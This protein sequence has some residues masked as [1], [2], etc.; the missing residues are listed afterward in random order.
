[1]NIRTCLALGLTALIS[2]GAAHAADVEK[3]DIK[4]SV[5]GKALLYYLPL[6]VTEKLG[7]FKDAGLN[8]EISDFAGG[9]QSLQAQ[10]GGSVD[11]TTGS[12]EH[13]IQ[14]QAQGKPL[15][16]VVDLGRYPGIALGIANSRVASYKSI[17][18]LKGMRIGVTAPGSSTN[19]MVSYLMIKAGLKPEDASFI[20]VGGGAS[21]VAAMRHGQIDA[22]S[23]TDP[24]MSELETAGDIQ[25]IADSRT[26]E[27]TN[28]IYGGPSPAAVLYMRPSF[29]QAN[30]KTT[31]A[32]VDALVRGLHWVQSHSPEQ[33]ADLMPPE[34][35]GGNKTLYT[36]AIKKSLAIYSPDGKFDPAACANT[37]KVLQV[38]DDKVKAASIDLSKTYDETFVDQAQKSVK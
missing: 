21:A 31:Q 38:F 5:G 20:G 26:A 4:L 35:Q 36:T 32:L 9:S 7:Y 33:I 2:A 10:I 17:K 27:G 30:P 14:M 34:Y 6:T 12:Y 37:L 11:V 24:V 8:V 3:P 23:N 1:M 29:I 25:V 16:A 18:D 13:T 22:I 15:V 19:F 28:Q